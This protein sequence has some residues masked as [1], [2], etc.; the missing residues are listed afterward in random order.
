M[1]SEDPLQ[2]FKGHICSWGVKWNTLW[3]WPCNLKLKPSLFIPALQY[4]YTGLMLHGRYSIWNCG[5][6][7]LWARCFWGVQ[8]AGPLAGVIRG[9]SPLPKKILYLVGINN[10]ILS[11]IFVKNC[12]ILTPN[13]WEKDGWAQKKCFENNRTKKKW[14]PPFQLIKKLWPPFQLIK[15]SHDSPPYS[16]TPPLQ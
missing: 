9:Q 5:K 3:P 15:K 4:M 12:L 6:D 11:H 2:F 13:Y 14:W 1:G 8:E 16:T 7:S 10:I